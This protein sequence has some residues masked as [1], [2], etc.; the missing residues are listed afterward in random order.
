MI[1]WNKFFT[2][3]C[4]CF[5]AFRARQ[6]AITSAF[7]AR[8]SV[9]STGTTHIMMA[10]TATANCAASSSTINFEEHSKSYNELLVRL[11][12]IT[13]LNHA[14]AVLNYDRQ[15]FMPQNDRTSASRG[16]Q[17]AVLATIA[18][19]QATDPTIGKLI[20]AA[21]V[22]LNEL[23]KSS[24]EE[25]INASLATVKRV[26]ELEK[27]LY[28][29]EICIPTELAARKAA[30]E[31]SANHAWVKARHSNDF[32]SFAPALKDCFDTAVEI[33]TLRRGVQDDDNEKTSLYSQMLDQFEMGMP[34][35]RIDELFSQVQST[36]VPFIAQI[37]A[38]ENAPSLDA[39]S[40]KFDI[41]AQKS[42]CQKIA[43]AIGFDEEHG[44]IDVSVHPFTM[45]L[46]SADVRITS[47]FSD[48]EWYQGLMG[49]IH[50]AGHAM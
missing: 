34:S 21:T 19:K 46:S 1:F 9:T 6:V 37:R 18:H 41:G 24:G 47:R 20:D 36:L 8:R 28:N 45:S 29:K 13:H 39:L 35:S 7:V 48:D 43:T 22:D 14:S 32:A 30:L 10:N 12:E 15:V 5:L 11:R 25:V 44:R 3:H 31:A 49:T 50:E 42:V 2:T 40:G 27:D 16:K 4:C 26:L 17:L 23:L 33:A 38:C